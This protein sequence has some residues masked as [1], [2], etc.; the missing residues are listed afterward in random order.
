MYILFYIEELK[1]ITDPVDVTQRIGATVTLT[2]SSEGFQSENFTYLWTNS[3]DYS[4][5]TE[6]SSSGTSRFVIPAVGL[7]DAGEYRCIVQNEWGQQV[8]SKSADIQVEIPGNKLVL[9]NR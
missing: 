1:I 9:M 8:T 3:S 2:C 6:A 5:Y 7:S 4:V